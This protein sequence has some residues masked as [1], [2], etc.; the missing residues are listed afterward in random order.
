MNYRQEFIDLMEKT[1]SL[2]GMTPTASKILGVLMF[3]G[4][5]LSFSE[6]ARQLAVSRGNIS[7]NAK[8]LEECK[9]IT[10]IH[11]NGDRQDYFKISDHLYSN[12]LQTYA[13][14]LNQAANEIKVLSDSLPTKFAGQKDRIE[15]LSLI[16]SLLSEAMNDT[17]NKIT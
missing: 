4:I 15:R 8:V 11:H 2:Q 16:Y 3:D 6:I 13:I 17:G 12:I 9:L 10:R 7:M 5:E 14:S 1:A